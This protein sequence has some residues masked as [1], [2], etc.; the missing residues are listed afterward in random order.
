M[1]FFCSKTQ[2]PMLNLVSLMSSSLWQ[3]LSLSSSSMTLT[4][5]NSTGYLFYRMCLNLGLCDAFSWL[6]WACAFWEKNTTEIMCPWC[7]I[8]R[9]LKC[10]CLTT[11]EVNTNLYHLVKVPRFAYKVTVFPLEL[12]DVLGEMFLDRKYSASFQTF[13]Y[14]F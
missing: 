7:I 2:N 4:F 5:L 10:W 8:S 14:L 3:L 12:M 13:A 9:G 1:F 6:E 11:G